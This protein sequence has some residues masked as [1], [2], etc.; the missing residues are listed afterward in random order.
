MIK[1]SINLGGNA[2]IGISYQ[3]AA[4]S[5]DIIAISANG[6]SVKLIEEP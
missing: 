6:T 5:G 1:E 2:I 3:I 4:F